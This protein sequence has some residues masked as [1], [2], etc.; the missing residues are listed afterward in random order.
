[1]SSVIEL[2]SLHTN[3]INYQNDFDGFISDL[4]PD[5]HTLNNNSPFKRKTVTVLGGMG[6]AATHYFYGLVVRIGQVFGAK[7]DQDHANVNMIIKPEC[8]DRSTWLKHELELK[9]MVAQLKADTTLPDEQKIAQVKKFV[10]EKMPAHMN[11]LPYLKHMILEA[12]ASTPNLQLIGSAINS[13]H[14]FY[15]RLRIWMNESGMKHIEL[16]HAGEQVAAYLQQERPDVKRVGMIAAESTIRSGLFIDQLRAVGIEVVPLSPKDVLVA[17]N[18]VRAMKRGEEV[19]AGKVFYQLHKKLLKQ[20]VDLVLNACT[21][22]SPAVEA[23]LAAKPKL[24][25]AYW[26]KAMDTM[27]PIV[28]KLVSYSMTGKATF[29]VAKAAVLAVIS[30]VGVWV[31]NKFAPEQNAA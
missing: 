18:A 23:Y 1:M 12:K 16:L 3:T 24:R 4:K 21:E 17:D 26:A 2:L 19:A 27:E 6:P 5:S 22:V 10:T 7:G 28:R 14:G 11:P 30:G 20:D 15:D 13:Y 8:P 9:E 31:A 25:P 29:T